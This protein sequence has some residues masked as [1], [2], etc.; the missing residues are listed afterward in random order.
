MPLAGFGL[1]TEE[2]S[3]IEAL[4]KDIYNENYSRCFG[5]FTTIQLQERL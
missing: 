1:Y 5:G 2:N 3:Y 4:I